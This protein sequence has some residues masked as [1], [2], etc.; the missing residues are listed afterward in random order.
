[1]KEGQ[2]IKW[3]EEKGPTIIYQTKHRRLESDQQIM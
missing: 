1:M 3:P 2:T